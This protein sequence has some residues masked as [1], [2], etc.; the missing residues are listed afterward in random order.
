MKAVLLASLLLVTWPPNWTPNEKQIVESMTHREKIGSYNVTAR[1]NLYNDGTVVL[2]L[3]YQDIS[4]PI[5]IVHPSANQC[6]PFWADIGVLQSDG[7]AFRP[8]P[9][10]GTP[11]WEWTK[12][13][14]TEC[15][16][17]A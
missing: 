7:L 14:L 8:P 3:S 13:K 2:V 15:Q 4:R 6:D 17:G 11:S 16:A 10:W 1:Y 9:D 5:I 12:S